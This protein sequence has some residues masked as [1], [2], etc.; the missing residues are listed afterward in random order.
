MLNVRG[1]AEGRGQK[2]KESKPNSC[3]KGA[4]HTQTHTL[5]RARARVACDIYTNTNNFLTKT[6][7]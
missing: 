2:Q 6:H 3:K 7:I 1:W 5:A 4:K